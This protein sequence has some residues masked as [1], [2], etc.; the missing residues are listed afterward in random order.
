MHR[1]AAHLLNL[2]THSP[3]CC[4]LPHLLKISMSLYTPA[5]PANDPDTWFKIRSITCGRC[6][7]LRQ[8]CCRR[9]PEIV[10]RPVVSADRSLKS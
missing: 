6:P 3:H 1:L 4:K 9:P 8:K 2:R 10:Q 5:T 7:S